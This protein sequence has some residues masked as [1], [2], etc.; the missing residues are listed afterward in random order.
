MVLLQSLLVT[1]QLLRKISG[2]R[3]LFKTVPYCTNHASN[4]ERSKDRQQKLHR[5]PWSRQLGRYMY[6]STSNSKDTSNS[7]AKCIKIPRTTMLN[8][9]LFFLFFLQPTF[10]SVGIYSKVLHLPPIRIH[11]VVGCWRFTKKCS[12]VRILRHSC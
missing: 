4:K 5:S 10:F 1:G 11:C 3:H 9:L 2:Q 6:P 8:L 12:T 7:Q